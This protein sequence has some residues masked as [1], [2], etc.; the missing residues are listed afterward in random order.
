MNVIAWISSL[1]N[2]AIINSRLKARFFSLSPA[3]K[4][5][6][7]G[8]RDSSRTS[9]GGDIDTIRYGSRGS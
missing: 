3:W 7:R 1:L 4:P 5:L 8:A 2:E 9:A 6:I